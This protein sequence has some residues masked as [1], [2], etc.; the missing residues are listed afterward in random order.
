MDKNILH[1]IHY[2]REP[3][4]DPYNVNFIKITGMLAST[5][6]EKVDEYVLK[7]LYDYYLESDI[8][9]LFVIDKQQFKEFI[10]KYLPIYLSEVNKND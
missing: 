7:Q 9:D 8:T 1:H 6:A 4:I 2:D 10:L 3:L 5:Y